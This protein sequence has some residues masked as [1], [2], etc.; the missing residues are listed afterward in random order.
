M[1]CLSQEMTNPTSMLQSILC[2][3]LYLLQWQIALEFL[4]AF[5]MLPNAVLTWERG[6]SLHTISTILR[7]RLLNWKMCL[8]AGCSLGT[9]ACPWNISQGTST[10]WLDFFIFPRSRPMIYLRLLPMDLWSLNLLLSCSNSSSMLNS[11]SPSPLPSSLT[12]LLFDI[13]WSLRSS[14]HLCL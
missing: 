10:T 7:K 13:K 12:N 3:A 4:F 2:A 9:T 1:L 6:S 11:C 14:A 5:C 8:L